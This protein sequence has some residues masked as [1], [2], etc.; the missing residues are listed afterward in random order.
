MAG[1]VQERATTTVSGRLGAF[2]ARLELDDV[3]AEVVARAKDCLV[4]GL[5]VAAAG[6]GVGYG[7]MAE[8]ALGG[9]H[10]GGAPRLLV[11]GATAAAPLPAL[12][13]SRLLHARAQ[14]DTHGTFHPG[15]A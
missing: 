8:A 6:V 5:T 10:G 2:A 7:E 12:A 14:G 4:H 15:V 11:S 1:H 9:G 13:N 3:P